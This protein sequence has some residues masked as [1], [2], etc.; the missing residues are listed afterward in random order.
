MNALEANKLAGSQTKFTDYIYNRILSAARS[1]AYKIDLNSKEITPDRLEDLVNQGYKISK[2]TVYE[3][4][5]WYEV[6]WKTPN[7]EKLEELVH[8][9]C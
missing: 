1:G 3:D 6:S 7:L 4:E 2:W 5:T 8:V 9:A